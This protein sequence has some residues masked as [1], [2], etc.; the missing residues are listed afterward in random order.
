MLS[1]N[2]NKVPVLVG[3][4]DAEG[5]LTLLS[6]KDENIWEKFDEDFEQFVPLDLGISIGSEASRELS[7]AMKEFYFNNQSVVG[8][9]QGI[10][11]IT[12]DNWFTRGINDFVR[13]T[14][15]KQTEPVFYYEYK[16]DEHSISK[17]LFGNHGI[18]GACHMD[19]LVNIFRI[20][21]YVTF[22]KETP[23]MLLTRN[24]MITMWTNFIKYG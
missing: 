7:K 21:P 8:N 4:N 24:R 16:F 1:G 22:V 19:E 20:P 23:T 11:N 17:L 18:D 3:F 15:E 13:L 5:L 2:F 9:V 6:Q 12:G 10:I 14:V